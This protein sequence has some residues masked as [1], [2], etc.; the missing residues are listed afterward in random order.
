M[1]KITK[2][3][4][5]NIAALSKMTIHEDEVDAAMKRLQ[6]VLEYAQRVQDIAQDVEI[7]SHKNINHDR[8]DLVV[9]TDSQTILKQAPNSEDN[10]FV[11][12]KI[13]DN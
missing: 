11:V 5:L 6:D 8:E 13:L 3:E 9:K 2:E 10:Y 7:P 12:P 4:V 1:D